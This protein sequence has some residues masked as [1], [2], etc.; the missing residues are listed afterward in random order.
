MQR[1]QNTNTIILLPR[2]LLVLASSHE[3]HE[4]NR[5]RLL[6]LRFLPFN[7]GISRLLETLAAECR[8]R[9]D[10]LRLTA[11]RLQ[12]A[13][14]TLTVSSSPRRGIERSGRHFF[15][16]NDETAAMLLAQALIGEHQSLRFYRQLLEA[17]GTPELYPLIAALMKQ[18]LA[19]CRV[20][21]EGQSQLLA[22][23]PDF[24]R[25]RIA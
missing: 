6:A 16:I 19:Q 9:L 21:Q 17:N 13:G 7:I 12:M 14:P 18:S 22:S 15:V 1:A 3:H 20:L 4:M 24:R 25:Q 5:Y 11:E 2:E 23:E 10:E 8:Q